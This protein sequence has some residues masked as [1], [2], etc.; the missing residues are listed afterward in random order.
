M[1]NLVW[2]RTMVECGY[3]DEDYTSIPRD[4]WDA[5]SE[6]QQ[7]DYVI[8]LAVGHQNNVAPCH[9]SIVNSEAVPDEYKE[10]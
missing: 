10:E 3:L 9:G 8:G 5:M 1:E 2:I 4:E 7:N 6:S